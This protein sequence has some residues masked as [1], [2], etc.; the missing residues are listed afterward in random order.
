MAC[1][2][3]DAVECSFLPL[4]RGMAG[5]ENVECDKDHLH[6]YNGVQEDKVMT[7]KETNARKKKVR[8]EC[9]HQ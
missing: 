1:F 7:V 3:L 6:Q 5:S 9:V 8:I 4:A 2:F